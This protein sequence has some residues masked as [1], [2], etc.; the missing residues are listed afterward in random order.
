MSGG[1]FAEGFAGI[2]TTGV[3]ADRCRVGAAGRETAI[4]LVALVRGNL[5][6]SRDVALE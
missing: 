3:I 6:M 1:I 2:G 4:A 5:G